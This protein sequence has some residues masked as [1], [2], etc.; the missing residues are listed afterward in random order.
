[1]RAGDVVIG[2]AVALDVPVAS[3]GLRIGGALIDMV[4]QGVTL[5][6]LAQGAP[7]FGQDSALLAAYF[8]VVLAFTFVG[9]PTVVEALSGGL[10][11]GKLACGTRVVRDD[12]G[13]VAS[14]QC[15]VR[16][17]IGFVEIWLTGGSVGLIAMLVNRRGKRLGDLAAGTF[18][19]SERVK[20]QTPPPAPMPPVLAG[21]ASTADI[22]R[23]PVGLAMAIR[24]FLLRRGKLD[25]AA[26]A[27]LAAQLLARV[28]PLVSP[29]P[30][31]WVHQEDVLLAVIA[32]RGRRDYG[33]LM[34]DEQLRTRL[35]PK[36]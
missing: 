13:P 10:S 31:E 8:S 27:R 36:P 7:A 33:R 26:R 15:L 11:L 12:S 5:M 24:Q 6:V 28:R 35:L 4:V 14:R 21:W 34:A 17:L 30:P 19:V 2:E 18:V 9:L 23:L 32:E 3:V 20:L 16:A 29:Q 1:M 22:G 25:P